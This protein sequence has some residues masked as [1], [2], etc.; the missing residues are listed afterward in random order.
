MPHVLLFSFLIL[1]SLALTNGRRHDDA[2]ALPSPMSVSADVAVY[3]A[4]WCACGRPVAIVTFFKSICG[5]VTS[6]VFECT[7]HGRGYLSSG[8]IGSWVLSE[9]GTRL[10]VRTRYFPTDRV[11]ETIFVRVSHEDGDCWESVGTCPSVVLMEAIPA[12]VRLVRSGEEGPFP[13][14][15]SDWHIVS[16]A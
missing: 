16:D 6:T 3:R 2:T 11:V 5:C 9:G 4:A 10:S 12:M 14:T 8:P 1:M 7:W 13:N 15:P